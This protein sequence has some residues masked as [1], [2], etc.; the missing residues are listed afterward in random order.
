MQELKLIATTDVKDAQFQIE[1]LVL[2][3]FGEKMVLVKFAASAIT[4][5]DKM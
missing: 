4:L 2:T 3:E 1:T 5:Q